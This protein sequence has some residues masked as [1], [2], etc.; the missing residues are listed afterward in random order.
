MANNE[1]ASVSWFG[2]D[3][4]L[5]NDVNDHRLLLPRVS[6]A[7]MLKLPAGVTVRDVA[8]LQCRFPAEPAAKIVA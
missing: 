2:G 1:F 8:V 6:A 4:V 3:F 7:V 5:Y